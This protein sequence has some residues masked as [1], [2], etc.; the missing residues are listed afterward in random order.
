MNVKYIEDGDL[1]EYIRRSEFITI[2][3]LKVFFLL[4]ILLVSGVGSWK[5]S[6]FF[7]SV[8]L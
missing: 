2:P 4:D 1:K 6:S 3:F 5:E 8:S 7:S